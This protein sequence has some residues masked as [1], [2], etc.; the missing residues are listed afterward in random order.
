MSTLLAAE[1]GAGARIGPNAIIQVVGVLRDRFSLSFAEA[2]LRDA[3]PYTMDTMPTEMVDE[4]EAQAVVQALVERVGPGTATPVLREAGHRTAVYL[5]AHRIPVVAQL[6]MRALP[7]RLGLRLLLHA[8]SA[9]AWTF[10]GSGQFDVVRG[11][12]GTEL[13]FHDCAMCRNMREQQP[14]CDFY[15]GTFERLIGTLISPSVSVVEVECLA[16]GGSVCRFQLTHS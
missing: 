8:M 16:Q 7:E 4:R 13:V 6:L 11:A 2:V 9:N 5:M 1:H 3:T 10:A 15:A 12:T 14:M